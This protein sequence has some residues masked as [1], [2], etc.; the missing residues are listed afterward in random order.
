[1]IPRTNACV[2]EKEAF[3]LDIVKYE[4][5]HETENYL[6]GEF[7]NSYKYPFRSLVFHPRQ[8]VKHSLLWLFVCFFLL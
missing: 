6:S 2:K 4:E 7:I 3:D 5:A 8:K 1:M